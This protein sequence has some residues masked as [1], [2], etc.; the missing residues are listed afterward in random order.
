MD[1]PKNG[2]PVDIDSGIDAAAADKR[3]N[4]PRPATPEPAARPGLA[5]LV[6][7][8]RGE[9]ELRLD[10]VENAINDYIFD[11]IWK[12]VEP[13]LVTVQSRADAVQFLI[14]EGIISSLEARGDV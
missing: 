2:Q 13:R 4:E 5:D 8:G 1:T 7:W 10:E 3:G 9:K 11:K 6:A 14:D 12:I